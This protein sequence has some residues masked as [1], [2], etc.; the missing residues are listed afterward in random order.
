[1]T[2]EEF[3]NLT[4]KYMSEPYYPRKAV[5]NAFDS[6]TIIES[7][8][9]AEICEQLWRI[10]GPQYLTYRGI[11]FEPN[12]SFDSDRDMYIKGWLDATKACASS[13]R[14]KEPI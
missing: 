9:C 11:T 1:M 10:K 12:H 5:T 3:W 8:R 6:A 13:I 4:N 7:N 2:S 14:G